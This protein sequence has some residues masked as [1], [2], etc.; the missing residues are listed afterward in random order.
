MVSNR[1]YEI[2]I[3]FIYRERITPVHGDLKLEL[4]Q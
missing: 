2:Y 3:I 4:E 1:A